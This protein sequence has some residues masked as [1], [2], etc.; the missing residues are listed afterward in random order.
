MSYNTPNFAPTFIA[1]LADDTIVV[2][3]LSA[4]VQIVKA[5]IE[6]VQKVKAHKEDCMTVVTHICE[7]VGT[8]VKSL[9]GIPREEFDKGSRRDI[10]EFRRFKLR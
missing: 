6:V 1:N 8:L 5:L 7:I 4:A 9:E 2:P 3:E 10:D